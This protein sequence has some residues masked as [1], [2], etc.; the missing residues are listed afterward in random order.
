MVTIRCCNPTCAR[1][2]DGETYDR[3]CWELDM[4]GWAFETTWRRWL[5]PRCQ[6]DQLTEDK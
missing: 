6:T 5:C 4:A 1:T 2:E 3:L